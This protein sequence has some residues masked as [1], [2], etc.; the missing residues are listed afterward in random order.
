VIRPACP[1]D[2]PAILTLVRELA[3]YER[4]VEEVEATEELLHAALFGPDPRAHALIAEHDGA[5]AGFA[6][7]FVSFSTWLGRHGIYLEDLFVRPQ[8]RRL[9]YGRALMRE[10]ARICVAE[11]YGRLE[12]AVLDWNEPAIRFYR[13]LGAEPQDEWT[14][15][16]V[17]GE[18]LNRLAQSTG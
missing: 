16:R 15:H 4:A 7:W 2:V 8:L 1:E 18:A 14:V 9:G 3:E 17:R 6:V 13:A 10:L 5:V 12:W 11:G